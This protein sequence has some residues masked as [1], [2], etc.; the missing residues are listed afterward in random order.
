MRL[1]LISL[2]A[3]LTVAT[4]ALANEARVEARGGIYW[5]PAA[6]YDQAT[7]GI[8]AGYDWDLGSKAFGGVEVSGD[9]ILDG[10]TRVSF[11]AIARLGFKTS[12]AGKLYALG[13]YQSKPCGL[14]E[15][16]ATAGAGYQHGLGEKLYG[17]VEYRHFF[18]GNNVPDSN[19]VLVGLGTRF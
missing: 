4:P 15:D 8:A 2:A 14:C 17:K 19:A 5:M 16:S 12:E 9:K 10:G 7:A 13:G 11:G 18:T 1:A 3:A 6:N